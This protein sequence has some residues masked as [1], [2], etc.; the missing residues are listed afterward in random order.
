MGT[1]QKPFLS[2]LRLSVGATIWT[3]PFAPAS[4][5]G[6]WLIEREAKNAFSPVCCDI[7]CIKVNF[8]SILLFVQS[9]WSLNILA[10][11]RVCA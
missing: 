11:K 9:S 5:F 3:R 6:R 10:P 8:R 4:P 7:Q 1:K 2:L